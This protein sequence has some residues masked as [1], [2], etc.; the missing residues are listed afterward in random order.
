MPVR[1][2][3][4]HARHEHVPSGP[5]AAVVLVAGAGG[6]VARGRPLETPRVP[7]RGRRST[8]CSCGAGGG[9]AATFRGNASRSFDGGG[10]RP[11]GARRSAGRRPWTARAGAAC[12]PRASRAPRSRNGA[13]P[14]GPASRTWCPPRVGSRFGSGPS[15]APT[16]SWTPARGARCVRPCH[17]RPGEG[18]RDD[19]TSTV[20]PLL[21]R[22]ARQPVPVVAPGPPRAE[23]LWTLDS[24]TSVP[25]LA[26]ERRLGRRRAVVQATTC[27]WAGRTPGSTRYG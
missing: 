13:G 8:R 3:G 25:V 27:S 5:S 10:A 17:R 1:A 20:P 19:A 7:R 16:T 18:L 15:T 22:V 6:A 2:E 21:R 12:P 26:L 4:R 11:G 9:R 24:R 23:V 14:G